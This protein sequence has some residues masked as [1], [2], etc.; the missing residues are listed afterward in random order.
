MVTCGEG[1]STTGTN[2]AR[3]HTGR[4]RH[5]C[6][7]RATARACWTVIWIPGGGFGLV[8]WMLLLNEGYREIPNTVTDG[9]NGT[10]ELLCRVQRPVMLALDVTNE[11]AT[12]LVAKYA[13]GLLAGLSGIRYYTYG[14]TRRRSQTQQYRDRTEPRESP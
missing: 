14:L 5:A 7:T 2:T 8:Y 10:G 1:S 11:T 3:G 13:V 12:T 6:N 4:E 9:R